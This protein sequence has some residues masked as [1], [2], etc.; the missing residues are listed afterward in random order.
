LKAA[1]FHGPYNIKI[2]NVPE[3]ELKRRRVH[4]KFKAGSICGLTC[5]SIEENGNLRKAESLDMT[6][7]E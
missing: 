6:L 3:P 2:E 5:I 1:V 7:G 4:V